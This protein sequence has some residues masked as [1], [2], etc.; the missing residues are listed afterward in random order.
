MSNGLK[1]TP[2]LVRFFY[3]YSQIVILFSIAEPRFGIYFCI[4]WLPLA[5]KLAFLE[6][7][8]L[9]LGLSLPFFIEFVTG[10]E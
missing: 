10:I 7:S 5:H 6:D 9:N 2:E 1:S 8:A 4:L 3:F